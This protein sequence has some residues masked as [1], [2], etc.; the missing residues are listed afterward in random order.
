MTEKTDHNTN[1]LS[2]RDFLFKAAKKTLQF[3]AA[4][5]LFS[6]PH[7]QNFLDYLTY[8]PENSRFRYTHRINDVDI[9]IATVWKTAPTPY[10]TPEGVY[11]LTTNSF[12]AKSHSENALLL[13]GRPALD[14]WRDSQITPEL[15]KKNPYLKTI[16]NN[17]NDLINFWVQRM[18]NTQHTK[19]SHER[20][21]MLS[22]Y[23]SLNAEHINF[24]PNELL[25]LRSFTHAL[26]KELTYKS[27]SEE[28]FKNISLNDRLKQGNTNCLEF[29]LISSILFAKKPL[30]MPSEIVYFGFKDE[31]GEDV[32][33][34]FNVLNL[35]NSP[36]VADLSILGTELMNLKDYLNMFSTKGK[37]I[38]VPLQ[39]TSIIAGESYEPFPW[40]DPEW[41]NAETSLGITAAS[42]SAT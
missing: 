28:D 34:A 7:Y 3:G 35:N 13:S 22:N 24:T 6:I 36:V 32:Y 10:S 15:I 4:S 30:S 33:H 23:E 18:S 31:S 38:T 1:Q 27:I 40:H 8:I 26:A 16:A 9:D 37:N 42:K 39:T 11:D 12:I 21:N 29:S 17:A 25:K 14:R 5:V 2:R 19:S 20:S 41:I